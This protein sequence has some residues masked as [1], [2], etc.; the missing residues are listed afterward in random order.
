VELSEFLTA[1][2]EE[3]QVKRVT[4]REWH[5]ETCEHLPQPED[6][7]TFPCDCGVPERMA[8][9]CEAKRRIVEAHRWEEFDDGDGS[10]PYYTDCDDCR[11]SPPCRTLRLLAL[12]Y[13]DHPDYRE[14]WR[15]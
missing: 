15:P 2:I 14:E 10:V 9:E 7:Y 13:A 4:M 5:A 11:Q 3:D 12:P 1:R 8:V 6:G